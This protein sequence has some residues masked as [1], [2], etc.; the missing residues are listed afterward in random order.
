METGRWRF[1]QSLQQYGTRKNKP[2]CVWAQAY[3]GLRSVGGIRWVVKFGEWG[4]NQSPALECS[5]V[6]QGV[7]FYCSGAA[8]T[9]RGATS[10]LRLCGA[11]PREGQCTRVGASIGETRYWKTTVQLVGQHSPPSSHLPL[12]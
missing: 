6:M 10:S 12:H 1:N 4:T 3:A 2:Q 8:V 7:S 9:Q 5:M 11:A